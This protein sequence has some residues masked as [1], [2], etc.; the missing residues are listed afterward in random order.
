MPMLL[1]ADSSST[2]TEWAIVDGLNVEQFAVTKG[3]NPFFR[4]RREISHIIRL[5]LPEIFFHTRFEKAYFYGAG[6]SSPEK[7]KIVESSVVAQFRTPVEIESDLLGAARG[8]LG[9]NE[10]L[11]CILSTGANSCMYDGQRIVKNVR[12]GGYVLGDEGSNAFLGKLLLSDIIKDL[13]PEEVNKAFFADYP[14]S[15]DDILDQVYMSQNPNL[16]LSA[17]AEFLHKNIGMKYCR[18][19]VYNAFMLFFERNISQY[20]YRSY[21]LSAVGRTCT[22]FKTVLDSAAMAFGVKMKK[23]E[24]SS[25][26]GLIRYHAG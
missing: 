2:R 26:Q 14:V 13:V 10:G 3:L 25:L 12:P 24:K 15:I 16:A 8:L 6:C 22:M 11:A 5:E 19:L 17:Y 1:I 23:I 21:P 4:T 18:D 20:D 9:H 7:K